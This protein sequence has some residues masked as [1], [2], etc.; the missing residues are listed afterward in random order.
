VLVNGVRAAV[1]TSGSFSALIAVSPGPNEITVVAHDDSSNTETTWINITYVDHGPL[2]EQNHTSAKAELVNLTARIALPRRLDSL[3]AE[4]HSIDSALAEA[5]NNSAGLASSI[6]ALEVRMNA[7]E[8]GLHDAALLLSALR[9]N[10]E[11]LN[12]SSDRN[13][14]KIDALSA[15]TEMLEERYFGLRS[16][17][18]E[19]SLRH[20]AEVA[21]ARNS[22]AAANGLALVA[23]ALAGVA[24][25]LGAVAASRRRKFPKPA[26][27]TNTIATEPDSDR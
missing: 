8:A 1:T 10:L 24:T 26:A 4:L 5:A 14:S 21:D 25:A 18:E 2:I 23:L 16:E 7:T 3:A 27:D 12:G 17:I 13:F 9:S 22:A 20:R 11:L 19:A 6:D 15:R